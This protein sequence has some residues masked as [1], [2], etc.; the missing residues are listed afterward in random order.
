MCGIAGFTETNK[1]LLMQMAGSLRHR[2]PDGGGFYQD[3]SVSL[4]MRRLAIVDLTSGGQPMFNE[5]KTIVAFQNGEIYNHRELR[6]ELEKKG[7]RFHSDHSDTEVI[8]HLYEEYGE[9]WANHTNGMFAAAIWDKPQKRLLLYRDRLGKKPLYYAQTGEVLIFG[10]EIKSLL[11]H[12][13]ISRELD[14]TSI[15]H[16]LGLKN[17]QAPRTIYRDI[18]QILPGE[19]LI[20]EKGRLSTKKYWN[21]NFNSIQNEFPF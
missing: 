20:W 19:Y 17:T 5:D 16:Y 6:R 3:E 1:E 4:G 12:P 21:L 15:Y 10:S 18:R 13:R 11:L 7:H 8:P 14:F 9:D 2:G